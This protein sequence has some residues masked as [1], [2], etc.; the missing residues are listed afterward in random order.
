M[1]N[2]REF[3]GSRKFLLLK[4]MFQPDKF[5]C[6]AKEQFYLCFHVKISKC[7]IKSVFIDLDEED[8]EDVLD[9]DDEEDEEEGN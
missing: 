3:F 7:N 2:F 6:S 9:E 8:D 1:Q 5:I 4:Y